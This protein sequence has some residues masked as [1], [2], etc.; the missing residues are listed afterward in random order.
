[1]GPRT[2]RPGEIGAE[3][4]RLVISLDGICIPLELAEGIA[5]LIVGKG[6]IGF[7]LN[8]LLIGLE[9]SRIPLLFGE[10]V[11][12]LP[13][14]RGVLRDQCKSVFASRQ[15]FI[16]ALKVGKRSGLGEQ[17]FSIPGV[18]AQRLLIA[19]KRFFIALQVV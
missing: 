7:E 3:S 4:N 13:I 17:G 12:L 1:M 18:A 5:Y 6:I 9:R 8:H 15:R 2:M 16:E 19:S 11:S 10:N 14:D